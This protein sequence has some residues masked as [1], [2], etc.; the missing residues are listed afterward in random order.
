M[1][2]LY[3]WFLVFVLF[4]SIQLAWAD[5]IVGE[6]ELER[7]PIWQKCCEKQ[8]C[9]PEEVN[10]IGKDSG[11]MVPVSIEGIR[12][13]VG[14]EKFSPVPSPRTWVCYRNPNGEI[15]DDNI[16]CILYPQQGGTTKAPHR[17]S[18]TTT[19]PIS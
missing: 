17:S 7:L 8:D 13:T 15:N 4:S 1:R 16:R 9:V 10:I 11:G 12:T 6:P 5:H 3:S 14:K 2:Q 19:A 18:P